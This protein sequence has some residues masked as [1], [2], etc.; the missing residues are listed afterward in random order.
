VDDETQYTREDLQIINDHSNWKKPLRNIAGP[1]ANFVHQSYNKSI[2]DVL[3]SKGI[4]LYVEKGS[5][6]FNPRKEA[7]RILM[8]RKIRV[9]ENKRTK[10]M[11]MCIDN[12]HYPKVKRGGM[13]EVKSVLPVHD[14]TEA[15]RSALEYG[16]FYITRGLN[17][18]SKRVYD[19]IKSRN[20][21]GIRRS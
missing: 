2:N 14:F 3:R 8:R 16:A 12:A 7:M 9:N 6:D 19:S 1:D 20:P 17:E 15:F 10:Y 13:D 11:A 21:F 18:G 4:N 5:K